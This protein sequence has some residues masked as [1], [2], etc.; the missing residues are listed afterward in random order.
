LTIDIVELFI[1]ICPIGC[2]TM[3]ASNYF[4]GRQRIAAF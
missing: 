2:I 4:V 3:L 1:V